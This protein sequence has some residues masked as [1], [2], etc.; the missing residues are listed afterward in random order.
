[1]IIRALKLKCDICGIE[2][3]IEEPNSGGW[4]NFNLWRLDDD[5]KAKK[6]S[7][8]CPYC[9]E[10]IRQYIYHLCEEGNK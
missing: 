2:Q 8:V 7:N 10:K 9:S 1:M 6:P 4:H 5:E 3:F